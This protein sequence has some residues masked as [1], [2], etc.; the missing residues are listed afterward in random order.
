M[1]A[2]RILI[3]GG[4]I[5]ALAAAMG[6]AWVLDWIEKKPVSSSGGLY[7]P[8]S[9]EIPGPHFFQSDTAWA[10]EKLAATEE[11]LSKAGCAVSSAAMVLA[12]YGADTDP[13]KL[14]KFLQKTPGGYT[15]EGWIYWEKAAEI[16][17]VLAAKVLP[18][19][20]NA[21]SGFLI[22]WNLLTG[23]PVIVRIRY[24]D[25]PT[26]FV[27]ICGKRGFDYLIRD[28]GAA[29]KK[30]VYPLKEIASS[31]EALRFYKKP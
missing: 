6:T 23:N 4:I 31:V 8:C 9:F 21:P 18:H 26:H 1:S 16:D 7:F 29:G 24:P 22:D 13:G 30:G 2:R 10:S 17:P 25:G 11:T 27:V 3:I 12:F 28:P 15:P 14:N 5:F 19:Y 20:E